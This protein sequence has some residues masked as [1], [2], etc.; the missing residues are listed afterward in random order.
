MS[1]CKT[2][3]NFVFQFQTSELALVLT[4]TEVIIDLLPLLVSVFERIRVQ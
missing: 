3:G 1:Y 2:A 4:C